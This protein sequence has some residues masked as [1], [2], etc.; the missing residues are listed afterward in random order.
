D[1]DVED[2]DIEAFYRYAMGRGWGD[3]LPLVP[4]TRERVSAMLA[5]VDRAH[6]E[7]VA[8]VAPA[9]GVATVEKIAINAVMAGCLPEHLPVVIAAVEACTAPEFTLYG[10]QAT[11]N[12]AAPLV[13]VNGPIR[14]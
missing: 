1:I 6:D 3:G 2:D 4:P 10:I 13:L 9:Y 8:S 5:G 14:A 11:T 12:P 7:T